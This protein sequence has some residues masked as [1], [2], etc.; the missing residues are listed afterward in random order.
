[1]NFDTIE[2]LFLSKMKSNFVGT[3]RCVLMLSLSYEKS[4]CKVVLGAFNFP[5]IHVKMLILQFIFLLSIIETFDSVFYAYLSWGNVN[6]GSTD[7]M[8]P[9]NSKKICSLSP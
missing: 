2:H 1:M 6:A 7:A 4:I 9:I 3:Q 8:A 5:K